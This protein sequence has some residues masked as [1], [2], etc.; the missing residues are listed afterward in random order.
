M[1]DGNDRCM[2]KVFRDTC[3]AREESEVLEFHRRVGAEVRSG[4]VDYCVQPAIA[5]VSFEAVYREGILREAFASFGDL[6][7]RDVLGSLKTILAVPLKVERE[8]LYGKV[9][10]VMEVGGEVYLERKALKTLN[11]ERERRGDP[12]FSDGCAVAA[13]VFLTGEA[14]HSARVPF[15]VFFNRIRAD[16]DAVSLSSSLYERLLQ[17]QGWGFRIDRPGMRLCRSIEEVLGM[18]AEIREKRFEWPY[19]VRGVLIQPDLV[20]PNGS[21]AEGF[22]GA[23]RCLI[24][25]FEGEPGCVCSG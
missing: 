14:R 1:N 13:D 2:M 3:V 8:S 4:S 25:A 23:C 7:R 11:A 15:N 19:E 5:G 22:S 16:A 24:Y 12:L 10:E 20:P 18:C 17:I 9:P 6:H 21:G